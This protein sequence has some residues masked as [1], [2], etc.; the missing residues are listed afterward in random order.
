MD[1]K[2]DIELLR[3][4]YVDREWGYDSSE[5]FYDAL[6]RV[7]KSLI[8]LEVLKEQA[9]HSKFYSES[10]IQEINRKFDMMEEE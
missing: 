5:Q 8:L 10:A 7:E 1:Y 4:A 6:G 3:E 2:R 9:K